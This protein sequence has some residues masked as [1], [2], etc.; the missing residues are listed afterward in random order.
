MQCLEQGL[1][2][3]LSDVAVHSS[4][5]LQSY[6]MSMRSTNSNED[7]TIFMFVCLKINFFLGDEYSTESNCSS[8][9]SAAHSRDQSPCTRN[10]SNQECSSNQKVNIFC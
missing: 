4:S 5:M 6:P 9:S 10:L 7:K 8:V 3:R 2:S 1:R